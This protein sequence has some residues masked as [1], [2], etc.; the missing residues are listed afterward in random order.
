MLGQRENLIS[1]S[2]ACRLLACSRAT[3][4]GY[5]DAWLLEFVRKPGRGRQTSREAIGRMLAGVGP[6]PQP[7]RRQQE[8]DAAMLALA[9]KGY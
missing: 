8:L 6:L 7:R 5:F 2:A 9:A 4:D 3:L 1:R